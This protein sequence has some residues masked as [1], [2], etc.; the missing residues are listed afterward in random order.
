MAA[1]KLEQHDRGRDAKCTT[2]TYSLKGDHL[3]SRSNRVQWSGRND[4][5]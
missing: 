5:G 3:D 2:A 4:L 1:H